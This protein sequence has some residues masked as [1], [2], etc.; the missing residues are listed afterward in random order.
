MVID[1]SNSVSSPTVL[2]K[3]GGLRVDLRLP[4]ENISYTCTRETWCFPGRNP[5]QQAHRALDPSKQ[6]L[7]LPILQY[8]L[9]ESCLISTSSM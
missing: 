7:K 3:A 2:R 1:T 9:R 4:F 8:L 5:S 6:L